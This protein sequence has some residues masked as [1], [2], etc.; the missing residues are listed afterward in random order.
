MTRTCPQCSRPITSSSGPGRPKIYCGPGCRRAAEFE[1]KRTND[2]LAGLEQRLS[3]SRLSRLKTSW[4]MAP[5]LIEAEIARQRQRLV[6]LL[7]DDGDDPA[8]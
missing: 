5:A 3:E 7:S 1:I 2:R 4:D 6:E 8:A